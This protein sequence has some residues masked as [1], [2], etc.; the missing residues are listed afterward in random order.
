VHIVHYGQALAYEMLRQPANAKA[1]LIRA[2][3]SNPSYAPARVRLAAYG[4]EAPTE[5]ASTQ[6]AT[7]SIVTASITQT[8]DD[9]VVRKETLPTAVK[10]PAELASAGDY[11]T[12]LA[13][14]TVIAV[15]KTAKVYTDRLPEEDSP[16][17]ETA[18]LSGNEDEPSV[19]AKEKIVAIEALPEKAE[20]K[21][22]PA[23]APP[24]ESE[25]PAAAAAEAEPAPTGWSVQISSAVEED[26]AWGIWKKLKA[27]HQLLSDQKAIVIKADLGKKGIFYRLRLAGFDDRSEAQSM[28]GKLKSRGVSCF[29]SKLDS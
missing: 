1:A 10:P 16:E 5:P 6:I 15:E 19:K 8:S 27:K 29:V 26:L 3:N 20:A 23:S 13:G 7:D 17:A 24:E 28:C 22:E 14:E 2:L 21:V 12:V 11:Q 4:V 9:Q 18:R 25:E